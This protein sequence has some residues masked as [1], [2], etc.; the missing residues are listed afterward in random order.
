MTES[1]SVPASER[2]EG[3][4]KG[5]KETVVGNEYFIWIYFLI[6]VMVSWVFTH[7]RGDPPKRIYL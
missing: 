7:I 1:R 2:E 6:I 5:H 3:I 4:T